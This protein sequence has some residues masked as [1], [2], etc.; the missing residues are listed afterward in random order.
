[1]RRSPSRLCLRLP[2]FKK[3]RR[4]EEESGAVSTP[5]GM[6]RGLP[7]TL[8]RGSSE[9]LQASEASEGARAT[10]MED[11]STA[12][13]RATCRRN[14]LSQRRR[15]GSV[16]GSEGDVE[17]PEM[18]ETW[19]EVQGRPSSTGLSKTVRLDGALFNR[20]HLS[21][22]HLHGELLLTLL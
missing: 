18:E 10:T 3:S 14:A 13:S 16:E 1:V 6:H 17:E 5:F 19:A 8:T 12:G 7:H 2:R 11:A 22:R 9:G 4:P 21:L 20:A 15:E